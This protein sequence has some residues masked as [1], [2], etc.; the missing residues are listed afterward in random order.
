[1]DGFSP[2]SVRIMRAVYNGVHG[3][4]IKLASAPDG[5]QRWSI[6][7]RRDWKGEWMAGSM[8]EGWYPSVL[9][10]LF[11]MKYCTRTLP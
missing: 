11:A 10:N 8:D 7:S 6:I 3:D 5:W 4:A 9:Q 1:M 2:E